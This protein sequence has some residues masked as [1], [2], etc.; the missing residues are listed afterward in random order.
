M[1]SGSV[2]WETAQSMGTT[3]GGEMESGPVEE[4][5]V[6]WATEAPGWRS[7]AGQMDTQQAPVLNQGLCRAPENRA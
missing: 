1:S 3:S 5:Q 7:R 2:L 6:P 4:P